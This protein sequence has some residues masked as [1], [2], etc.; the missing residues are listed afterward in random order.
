MKKYLSISLITIT[1]GIAFWLFFL[2]LYK[3]DI[4]HR[5]DGKN[6]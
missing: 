1:S 4:F 6:E 2:P 5:K 3:V